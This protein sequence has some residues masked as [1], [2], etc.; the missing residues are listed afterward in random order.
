MVGP[1]DG[2]PHADIHMTLLTYKDL[3]K[4]TLLLI[5]YI[6]LTWKMH[7]F[8]FMIFRYSNVQLIKEGSHI[9]H[10]NEM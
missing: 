9:S 1:S 4:K 8:L 10:K 5:D 3:I 7:Y 6:D 2:I